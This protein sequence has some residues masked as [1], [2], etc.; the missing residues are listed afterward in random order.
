[1]RKKSAR[2]GFTYI[3]IIIAIVV[4]LVVIA[5]PTY[6]YLRSKA[7]AA[8]IIATHEE[9]QEVLYPQ[10]ATETEDDC[11]KIANYISDKY[12][13]DH[14][15]DLYLGFVT[16]SGGYRPVLIVH[17]DMHR[18]GSYGVKAARLAYDVLLSENV[19]E[20]GAYME[21]GLVLFNAVL[22][23]SN[24]AICSHQPLINATPPT[25]TKPYQVAYPAWRPFA[26]TKSS[27]DE[28]KP[29]SKENNPCGDGR[30]FSPIDG[31]TFDGTKD[32]GACIKTPIDVPGYD[33]YGDT[34]CQ[35]CTGPPQICEQLFHE[36]TCSWPNNVCINELTNHDNGTREVIRR[37][38]NADEANRD[39]Y[40]GTSNNDLCR[41]SVGTSVGFDNT[42]IITR[43]F[44]CTYACVTDNCN[45]PVS[46]LVN[47]DYAA[48]KT[49]MYLPPDD[50][51]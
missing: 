44:E 23:D 30:V 41:P 47:H 50:I 16:V 10:A 45:K 9:L 5:L 2:Q 28:S 20:S 38:G 18:N 48:Q 24:T 6:M 17:A 39:W 14:D 8:D 3:E 33:P 1:M 19:I 42:N 29:L 40:R 15:A 11:Q 12:F 25:P 7:S 35:V 13:D 27:F 51:K 36:T 49:F 32:T 37:C 34:N 22:V 26:P 4:P 31:V 46:P 21:K 43:E